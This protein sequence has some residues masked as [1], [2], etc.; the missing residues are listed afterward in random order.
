MERRSAEESEGLML[1]DKREDKISLQELVD[2]VATEGDS[3][4]KSEGYMEIETV[5]AARGTNRVGLSELDQNVIES[6]GR[7]RDTDMSTH[8]ERWKRKGRRVQTQTTTEKEQ[9]ENVLRVGYKRD[10]HAWEKGET[11]AVGG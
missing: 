5:E 3:E 11:E 6:L 4:N 7:K 1:V 10:A 8:G 9:K 2:H